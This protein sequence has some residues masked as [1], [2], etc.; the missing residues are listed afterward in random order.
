MVVPAVCF[1]DLETLSLLISFI[2]HVSLS[3]Y[4]HGTIQ[5]NSFSSLRSKITES[6]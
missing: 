4:I 1:L 3:G 6:N 5:N 2:S